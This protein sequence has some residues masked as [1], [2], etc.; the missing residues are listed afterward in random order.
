MSKSAYELLLQRAHQVMQAAGMFG[1]FTTSERFS[2]RVENEP[3]MALIIESH[4]TPDALVGEKRRVLVA[5]Y[6]VSGGRELP[7]PELEMTDTGFPIR[8]RQTAFGVMETPVLWRDATTGHVL[9]NMRA[10][11]DMAELLRAWAKNIKAQGFIEAASRI[12]STGDG[13]TVAL[14]IQPASDAMTGRTQWGKTEKE[15]LS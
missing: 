10:K 5:H 1:E 13:G 11:R 14:T 6:A 7:D 9:V 4:P 2:L 15:C 12:V 8:L 3:Y